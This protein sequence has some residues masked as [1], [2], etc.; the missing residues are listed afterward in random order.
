[1]AVKRGTIQ[2]ETRSNN[3][4]GKRDQNREMR[5]KKCDHVKA[6]VLPQT[7]GLCLSDILNGIKPWKMIET[8]GNTGKMFASSVSTDDVFLVDWSQDNGKKETRCMDPIVVN[9]V[10]QAIMKMMNESRSRRKIEAVAFSSS[11]GNL[12]TIETSNYMSVACKIN[13]LVD[14]R[15]GETYHITCE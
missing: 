13:S 3:Q 4:G 2:G 8:K 6:K 1:M 10:F 9:V 5:D 12:A 7:N 14:H 15:N 11:A